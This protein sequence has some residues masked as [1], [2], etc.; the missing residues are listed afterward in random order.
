MHPKAFEFSRAMIIDFRRVGN[1]WDAYRWDDQDPQLRDEYETALESAHRACALGKRL[2][3]A[4]PG[5]PKAESF[6]RFENHDPGFREQLQAALELETVI[7]TH[8]DIAEIASSASPQ[9]SAETFH[10]W[11]WESARSLFADTYY[12]QAI[13]TAAEVLDKRLAAKLGRTDLTG[14]KLIQEA[15][16]LN[17]PVHGAPRL[18]FLTDPVGSESYRSAHVG[19]MNFGQGLSTGFRNISVHH[20]DRP[21]K[22]QDA[23]E[24]LGA[25]SLFAKIIDTA[26]LVTYSPDPESE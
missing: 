12:R 4:I 10:P 6:D 14:N 5:G 17:D 2:A 1:A 23:L 24:I 20:P 8:D 16:S 18:R 22:E 7:A 3:E 25:L 15:F 9:L 11:V 21:M 26:T 19:A 13:A